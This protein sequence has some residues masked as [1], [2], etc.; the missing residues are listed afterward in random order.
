MH[1]PQREPPAVTG[2]VGYCQDFSHGVRLKI[3]RHREI[4]ANAEPG[5]FGLAIRP[6]RGGS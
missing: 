4:F 6:R 1:M 3:H 5:E 2:T